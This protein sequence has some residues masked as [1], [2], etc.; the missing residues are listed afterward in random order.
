MQQE[1]KSTELKI[2]FKTDNSIQFYCLKESD[3]LHIDSMHF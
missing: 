1:Y 2:K 3:S